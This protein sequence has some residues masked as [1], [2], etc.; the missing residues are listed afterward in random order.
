M[1][2]KNCS[3]VK[4][5]VRIRS[6]D[7]TGVTQKD[8]AKRTMN[9]QTLSRSKSPSRTTQLN[10]PRTGSKSPS[11][12]T[13]KSKYFFN[14]ETTTPV[15]AAGLKENVK[16][17]IFTSVS[18]SNTVVVTNN[19]ISGKLIN[20]TFLTTNDLFEYS[21]SLIKDATLLEYDRVYNESQK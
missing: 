1:D 8:E 3:N 10:K 12:N 18:P 11:N 9:E 14:T 7:T 17:S 5:L 15:I 21:Y 4:I 16:Y 2:T 13:L 6:P 20:S 19:P